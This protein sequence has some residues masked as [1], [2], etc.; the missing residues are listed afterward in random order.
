MMFF[1][2]WVSTVQLLPFLCPVLP[3]FSAWK[4]PHLAPHVRMAPTVPTNL[5]PWNRVQLVS[6][7]L[8]RQCDLNARL[9]LSV[10]KECPP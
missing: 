10:Q 3:A 1:A 2:R 7:A 8:R 4:D 9:A 6:F 5:A